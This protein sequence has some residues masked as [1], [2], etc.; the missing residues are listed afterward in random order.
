MVARS[1]V[2]PQ[3]Y[4]YGFNG[5]EHE[6]DINSGGGDYDFGARIYDPRTGRFLSMDPGSRNYAS[7]SPYSFAGNRPIQAIDY[8][9]KHPLLIFGAIGF[10]VGGTIE[11][12]GQIMDGLFAG[13]NFKEA[14]KKIDWAN[15]LHA[16]VATGLDAMTLGLSKG[17][18]SST[19]ALLDAEFD[20]KFFDKDGL[21]LK[22]EER[23]TF[24][25]GP[26][27]HK[28]EPGELLKDGILG[29]LDLFIDA[30][31]SLADKITKYLDD[32]GLKG[33]KKTFGN[34]LTTTLKGKDHELPLADMIVGGGI[35]AHDAYVGSRE[36]N[37]YDKFKTK[38]QRRHRVKKMNKQLPKV[39][40]LRKD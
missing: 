11:I 17:L 24:G 16:S 18:T 5:K 10:L 7:M 20:L 40:L 29:S 15:V 21:P 9:G 33:V 8:Q 35:V 13:D 32:N 12:G 19:H 26:G 30:K 1:A 31:F 34:L 28:K 4:R 22:K 6:D 36:D 37:A 23:L 3:V 14:F 27:D 2:S 25:F 39:Q 38:I